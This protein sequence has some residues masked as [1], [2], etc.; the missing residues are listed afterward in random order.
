MSCLATQDGALLFVGGD[1]AEGAIEAQV[2]G[3][4]PWRVRREAH[5]E[6]LVR[7]ARE[8]LARVVDPFGQDSALLEGLDPGVLDARIDSATLDRAR[9]ALPLRRDERPWILAREL[10]KRS[11][12]GGWEGRGE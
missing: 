12:A 8:E 2:E 1:G 6:D 4:V 3:D 11:E 5:G 7:C 10:A 9:V